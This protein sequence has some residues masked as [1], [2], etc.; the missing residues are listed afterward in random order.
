MLLD[1]LTKFLGL[2]SYFALNLVP[3]P[4]TQENLKGQWPE[5]LISVRI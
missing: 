4:P 2:K 3:T 1:I 5:D